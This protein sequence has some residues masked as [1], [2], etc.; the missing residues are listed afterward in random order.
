MCVFKKKKVACV[1]RKGF[2]KK[3][4]SGVLREKKTWRQLLLK[5]KVVMCVENK[6][7]GFCQKKKKS[8]VQS[9]KMC[10]ESGKKYFS[11]SIL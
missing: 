11:L 8:Y 3:K 2:S 6:G 7:V 4:T 10:S 9:G 5:K 1:H